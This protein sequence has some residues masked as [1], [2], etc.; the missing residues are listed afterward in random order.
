MAQVQRQTAK[1]VSIREIKTGTYIKEEDW[2][3]N[4]V[5]SETGNKISRVNVIALIISSP[6]IQEKSFS[7]FIDDG[8]GQILVRGFELLKSVH[9]LKIGDPL[10]LI[11][12]PRE[13]NNE[14]YI[15]AEILKVLSDTKWLEIRKKELPTT[16]PVVQV[17]Q[18][19]P[20][21][22]TSS[23]GITDKVY[24]LIKEL[25]TGKGA[26]FETILNK[27]NDEKTEQ[28]IQTLIQEGEIFE[29][30]PGKLK[31]LE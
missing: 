8:S 24:H 16:V 14:R 31:V 17:V 2:N 13:F 25:D 4:Y 7:F 18:E 22:K 27:M 10:L 3:P 6:N 11:G 21:Q 1:K 29:F 19:T 5:L 12:R 28:V 9:S 26:D 15:L 20:L 23:T 30:V